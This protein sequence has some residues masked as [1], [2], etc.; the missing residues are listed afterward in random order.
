MLDRHSRFNMATS[1]VTTTA[2]PSP[3]TVT[4]YLRIPASATEGDTAV[5]EPVVTVDPTVSER[6]LASE[7]P[8]VAEESVKAEV[9]IVS[10]N[11]Q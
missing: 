8:V 5:K 10:S 2:A 6:P 7:Q 3:N 1:T 4:Y 11:Q 9:P